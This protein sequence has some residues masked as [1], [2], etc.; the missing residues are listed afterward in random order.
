M[1]QRIQRII[2][3]LFLPIVGV[4]FWQWS[5]VFL[6]WYMLLDG[7]TSIVVGRIHPVRR[8]SWG[9][10]LL[11][12][13]ECVIAVCLIFNLSLTIYDSF[14]DF[15][16]YRDAGIPQGYFLLPMV[17]LGELLRW[18]AGR[19][20]GVYF[21]QPPKAAYAKIASYAV[22]IV[23]NAVGI[24]DFYLSLLLIFLSILVIL[25]IPQDVLMI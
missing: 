13:A 1:D 8:N 11:Q 16:F 3:E 17:V 21:F 15:F 23:L 4:L 18:K 9:L 25:F 19:K 7:L 5:T 12:F 10:T 24:P 2:A 6:L 14:I 20:I 22:L